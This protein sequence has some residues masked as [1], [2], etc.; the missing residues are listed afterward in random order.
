MSAADFR[1]V[2]NRRL[3]RLR[4]LD[5]VTLGKELKAM[6]LLKEQIRFGRQHGMLC[7][8][9]AD[10]SHQ[11][12]NPIVHLSVAHDGLFLIKMPEIG[13]GGRR[14]RGRLTPESVLELYSLPHTRTANRTHAKKQ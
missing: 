7:G 10:A 2:V 14:T 3:N 6:M 13:N 4:M 8:K 5:V 1:H 9:I 12:L 11:I